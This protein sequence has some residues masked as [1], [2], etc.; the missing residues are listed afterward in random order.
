M[1][2]DECAVPKVSNSLSLRR[3]KPLESALLAQGGHALPASGQ[4]F[5]GIGL[6]AARPRPSRSSGVL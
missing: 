6:V 1:L 4:D 2:V 5:V 3:G